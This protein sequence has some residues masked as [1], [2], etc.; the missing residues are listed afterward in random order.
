MYYDKLI[1]EIL[2][3]FIHEKY[4]TVINF[5]SGVLLEWKLYF[6]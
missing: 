2:E 3:K 6:L 1:L 5:L 4:I